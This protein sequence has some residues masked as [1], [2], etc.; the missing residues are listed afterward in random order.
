MTYNATAVL[1]LNKARKISRSQL[2]AYTMGLLKT[3]QGGLCAVCKRPINLQ[4]TGLKSDYVADHDHVHG[5]IRGILHRS[6]N[7]SLGKLENAVGRWG[8]KSMDMDIIIPFL[9]N[10]LAY[11]KQPFEHVIYPDHKTVEEKA[12]I[13]KQKAN[14]AAAVRKAKQK[15]RDAQQ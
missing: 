14:R 5:L 10:V 2:R 6:C 8:A 1:A 11:Y 15:L 3:K 7:A 12:A 4:L 9:E 13:T